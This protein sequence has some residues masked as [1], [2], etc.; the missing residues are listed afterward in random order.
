MIKK[1]CV[2]KIGSKNNVNSVTKILAKMIKKASLDDQ[3]MFVGNSY[4]LESTN[5]R[6]CTPYPLYNIVSARRKSESSHISML[7]NISKRISLLGTRNYEN[8]QYARVKSES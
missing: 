3:N 6:G 2:K 1:G 5:I 7:N 4:I 8:T